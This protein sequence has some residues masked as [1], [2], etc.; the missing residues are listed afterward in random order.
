[1]SYSHV[2]V[3]RLNRIRPSFRKFAQNSGEPAVLVCM[4]AER[5]WL[6][7][8]GRHSDSEISWLT[9]SFSNAPGVVF[10]VQNVVE[11]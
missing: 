10:A 11:D 4:M 5:G 6:R 8:G 2:R 9:D 7:L 1:M 3:V